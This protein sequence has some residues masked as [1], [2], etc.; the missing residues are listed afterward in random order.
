M[1]NHFVKDKE[2]FNIGEIK[3]TGNAIGKGGF[4]DGR[5]AYS[6]SYTGFGL[7]FS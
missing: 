6:L 2:T 5:F 3:V 1:T 4:V 7:L